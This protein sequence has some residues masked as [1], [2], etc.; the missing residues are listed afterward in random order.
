M[1]SKE[2]LVLGFSR[3]LEMMNY[4]KT[5]VKY[6]PVR[7]SDFIKW[8]Q[9]NEANQLH[10]I[11]GKKVKEY[12]VDLAKRK[13]E[14]TGE[15]LSIATQRKYLTTI[16]RFSRYLLQ[17]NQGQIEVP[18]TFKGQVKKSI[19]I[20]SKEEIKKL[21]DQC[22]DSL[23]GL[24]DRAMLSVIYGCGLR[25]NEARNVCITDIWVDKNLLFV[26]DGKGGKQRYVPIV[27]QVKNDIVNYLNTARPM[28]VNKQIEKAFFIGIQ[29]KPLSVSSLYERFK[30]L[31]YKSGISKKV[32]LHSLRHS[33]ATHLLMS[34]ME[35]KE[36]AKFLGHSSLESTQI[37]T[38]LKDEL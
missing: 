27:G 25:R 19:E 9:E 13:S 21:Y 30:S 5:S 29:G 22:D 36:I 38:H 7:L 28:L 8:M 12:F 2:K 31:L 32:G 15:V 26:R 24:R 6:G 23:L 14:K 37:Y 4:D 1:Y 20:L 11:S 16:K 18:V 3:W 17:T 10:E 34:G 35:L 33:I